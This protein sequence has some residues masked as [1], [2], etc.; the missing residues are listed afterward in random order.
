MGIEGT[1]WDENWVLYGS[2]FDNKLYFF[3]K[4][5]NDIINKE[6]ISKICKKLNSKKINNP[7]KKWE[8]DLYRHFSK[9]DTQMVNRHMERYSTSLIIRKMQIKTTMRYHLTPVRVTII[10]KIKNKRWQGCGER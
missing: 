7:I 9:E 10:K 2:Q 3:K 5:V 6:L 8:L 1:C 4:F